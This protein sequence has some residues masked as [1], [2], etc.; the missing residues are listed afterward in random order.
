MRNF[1]LVVAILLCSFFANAQL[2]AENYY[3]DDNQDSNLYETI[4]QSNASDYALEETEGN[5]FNKKRRKKKK[6]SSPLGYGIITGGT[7]FNISGDET[8]DAK[9]K[10]GMQFGLF[11]TYQINEMFGVKSG[12]IY[13]QKGTNFETEFFG[14][15]YELTATYNYINIPI[16]AT[17]SF[18]ESIKFY[19]NAGPV[20]GIWMSGKE[21]NDGVEED[22]EDG[23]NTIDMGLLV[24]GGVIIP[25]I[26]S[27][28]HP[29]ISIIA[30]V[31]YQLGFANIYDSD[32]ISIKNNGLTFGIGVLIGG[33]L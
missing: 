8:D 7:M 28:K 24:G 23:M 11:G 5:D 25:V 16:L 12:L 18:G 1:T 6:K 27:R 26:E 2:N 4:S 33:I 21:E 10:F 29:T 32:D 13:T 22:I 20:I 17:A 19:A 9:M 15:T 30:D 14:E 31:N 3:L